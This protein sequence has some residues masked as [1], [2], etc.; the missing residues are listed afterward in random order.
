MSRYQFL[1][2]RF[3]KDDYIVRA[4]ADNAFPDGEIVEI[5]QAH[6]KKI[7]TDYYGINHKTHN[8][9]KGVGVEI[10]TVKKILSLNKNLR[11]EDKEHVTLSIYKNSKYLN[12][13]L[14]NKIIPKKD[15]SN[16]SVSIDETKEFKL[17]K[18]I[19]SNFKTQYKFLIKNF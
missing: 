7:K 19:F 2:K 8:L 10:F 15:M 18:I 14:I 1:A 4:T 17:V 13:R 5:I 12:Q 6:V 9:P 16:I 3:K 11:K